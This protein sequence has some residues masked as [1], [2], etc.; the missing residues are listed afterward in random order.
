MEW[1]ALFTAEQQ[2]SEAEIGS[3]IDN[4]L[5]AELNGY[6]QQAYRSAPAT[7]YSGCS[8]QQGW[9]VKYRKSGKGL[10][11]LYPMPGYFIALVVVG[12]KEMNEAEL[13]MPLCSAYTQTVFRETEDGF[14]G[15]W[16]MLDVKDEAVL[17]DVKNLVNL[18]VKRKQDI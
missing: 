7:E 12:K 18:R 9:N 13:L 6:L 3:Y 14:Q 16:L 17:Q 4:G 8:M 5:W 2:P 11:T 10:C 1:N 15:K